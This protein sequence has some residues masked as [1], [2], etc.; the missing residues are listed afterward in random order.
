VLVEVADRARR[1]TLHLERMIAQE[2]RLKIRRMSKTILA[3]GPVWPT[4]SIISPP[5]AA[6][7][8]GYRFIV[9]R[10]IPAFD[11]R[12]WW[13]PNSRVNTMY[14]PVRA[15]QKT[16]LTRSLPVSFLTTEN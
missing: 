11:Y 3:T 4:S 16:R 6:A 9:F 15:V 14:Q 8:K 12:P 1:N 10:R 5:T 7:S 13:R 2:T